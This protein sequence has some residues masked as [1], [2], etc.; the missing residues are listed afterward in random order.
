[1]S[2]H[3]PTIVGISVLIFVEP[4]RNTGLIFNCQKK[5]SWCCGYVGVDGFR[6]WPR[7]DSVNTTCCNIDDLS[8][9]AADPIVY[10]TALSSATA[11]ASQSAI[12][13]TQYVTTTQVDLSSLPTQR[14][15]ELSEDKLQQQESSPGS[16]TGAK[17]GL[18]VGIPLAIIA[19]IAIG[20]FFWLRRRRRSAAP[21]DTSDDSTSSASDKRSEL[22]YEELPSVY[23]RHEAPSNSV[24]A[25][26]PGTLQYVTAELPNTEVPAELPSQSKIAK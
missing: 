5:E 19:F 2:L 3:E 4:T 15:D 10:A 20:T 13:V 22:P 18:G 8:F 6:G 11:S 26:L 21:K 16:N 9:K 24:V 7:Q 12:T 17:I 14:S 25:E 23:Y 1:V